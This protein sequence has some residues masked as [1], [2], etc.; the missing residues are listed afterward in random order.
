[1]ERRKEDAWFS[2]SRERISDLGAEKISSRVAFFSTAVEKQTELAF[3]VKKRP[4]PCGV[5]V[6]RNRKRSFNA[7]RIRRRSDAP[8]TARGAP[9]DRANAS[10][11]R[12]P[13]RRVW[14]SSIRGLAHLADV[15]H[16]PGVGTER[17]ALVLGDHGVG[18]VDAAGAGRIKGRRGRA[19]G[20]V[21]GRDAMERALVMQ[22]KDTRVD[23]SRPRASSPVASRLT[24]PRR[25]RNGKKEMPFPRPA[26]S[27]CFRLRARTFDR[28][29]S[30]SPR[31][32]RST[33][34]WPGS[35]C[36]PRRKSSWR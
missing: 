14:F 1:M 27:P 15:A 4:F 3:S 7:L 36:T 33:P 35:P 17:D 2:Q 12:L 9:H 13:S 26:R 31:H 16:G 29:S 28:T 20:S 10:A 30:T 6:T 25:S 22:S 24:A 11:S 32:R 5:S 8:A 23:A 18:G 19:R 34:R 21:P